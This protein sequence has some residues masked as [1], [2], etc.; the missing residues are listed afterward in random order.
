[1][2]EYDSSIVP[3]HLNPELD[4]QLER[5][6]AFFN[7]WGYMVVENAI[8]DYQIEDLRQ[9]LDICFERKDGQFIH[10]LLEEDERFLFLLDHRPVLRRMKAIL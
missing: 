4:A 5:E 9:A 7:Q 8:D 2:A 10:Q 6:V 3:Q 1:M